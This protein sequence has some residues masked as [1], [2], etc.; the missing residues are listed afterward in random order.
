MANGQ[1]NKVIQILRESALLREERAMTDG[2]LLEC[3]IA[4]REESAFEALVQRH[5]PMV[6]GVCRR[7]V[8]HAQDAEDAFQGT[9]L[10]LVRKAASI[11]P[12]ESVGN[13][14]YG[15]AYHTALVVRAKARRQRAKEKQVEHMPQPR[16]EPEADWGELEAML[17]RE[18][19]RLPDKYRLPVVLCELEG[20][21]RKAVAQQ[22]NL[23][24]GTLS[25]RLATARKLL[26]Q[27]LARR[28]L[29]L[30][31][32]ALGLVLS[33]KTASACVPRPLLLST[34]QAAA[35]GSAS[36][37]LA[38]GLISTKV[39]AVTGSVLKSM[40]MAKLKIASM[41]LLVLGVAGFGTG[42]VAWQ[43][44][45]AANQADT[46]SAPPEQKVQDLKLQR[47]KG[48]PEPANRQPDPKEI[49]DGTVPDQEDDGQ[50]NQ[51]DDGQ[52]NHKNDGQ[53]NQNDD[54][55]Q[56]HKND[57]QRNQN[58]D[59]QQNH[60]NDG[61]RNQNDDGQ[62][63]HKNDGQRNQNDDGQQNHMNDGDQN[64]LDD[65]Q[66]NQELL[67]GRWTPPR[68]GARSGV[69]DRTW[70]QHWN[71]QERRFPSSSLASLVNLPT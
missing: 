31:T 37:A 35:T 29:A 67:M 1:M 69:Q 26:A 40:L 36:E 59:G 15:V 16:T 52:Q 4:R 14:L 70:M 43:T 13:W 46:K 23:P 7:V 54:G 24:E 49:K 38:A 20:R 45:L 55:Q 27:R 25:S 6:L 66:K 5:G 17:D 61:Q 51:N 34:V 33:P 64:N 21:K 65:G 58:D 62:Q 9:F 10:V 39:A 19:S 57:G 56:N 60:K 12:R 71:W 32:V 22:L 44:P 28:G 42:I 30:S 47:A 18:L 48:P 11:A 3:F 41:V 68:T 8:G 50:Q 53:R 2:Q 63:N